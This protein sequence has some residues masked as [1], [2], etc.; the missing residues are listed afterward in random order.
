M[1]EPF[2]RLVKSRCHLAIGRQLL[3]RYE[4][5][6]HSKFTEIRDFSNSRIASWGQPT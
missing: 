2:A 3:L 5:P 4:G 1:R 6:V